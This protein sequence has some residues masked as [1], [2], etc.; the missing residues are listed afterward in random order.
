MDAFVMGKIVEHMKKIVQETV[1][2][3]GLFQC[4]HRIKI[5]AIYGITCENTEDHISV[6]VT[7][8]CGLTDKTAPYGGLFMAIFKDNS[9]TIHPFWTCQVKFN[10]DIMS[11]METQLK[12]YISECYPEIQI[13]ERKS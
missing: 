1:G 3:P 13:R 4:Y 7:Y 12:R 5:D 10:K 9:I 6:G 2:D 11:K 8:D